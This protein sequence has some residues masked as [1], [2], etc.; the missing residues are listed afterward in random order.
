MNYELNYDY[1]VKT[2]TYNAAYGLK[3]GKRRDIFEITLRFPAFRPYA[4]RIIKL[5]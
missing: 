3:A 5:R 1:D 4:R 2:L